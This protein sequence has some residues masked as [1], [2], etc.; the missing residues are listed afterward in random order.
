MVETCNTRNKKM[1]GEDEITIW[2]GWFPPDW[3]GWPGDWRG[4]WLLNGSFWLRTLSL[5]AFASHDS[6]QSCS[7]SCN[8]PSSALNHLVNLQI[9]NFSPLKAQTALIPRPFSPAFLLVQRNHLRSSN[10]AKSF[11]V[12][13]RPRLV[14]LHFP[15]SWLIRKKRIGKDVFLMKDRFT[16]LLVSREERNWNRVR[17]YLF[18]EI[19]SSGSLREALDGEANSAKHKY[20]I[21]I[22]SYLSAIYHSVCAVLRLFGPSRSFFCGRLAR[23]TWSRCT[24]RWMAFDF[25]VW[26]TIPRPP[27]GWKM[28]F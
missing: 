16:T 11:Q 5:K 4:S 15:H 22:I 27:F 17:V 10:S 2:R 9:F 20:K 14:N 28:D 8:E 12:P 1:W 26:F 7:F 6:S 25:H 24:T 21:N 18:T 23:E 13:P 3:R 19:S